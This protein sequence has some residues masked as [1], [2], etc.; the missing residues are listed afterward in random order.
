MI[1]DDGTANNA[2]EGDVVPDEIKLSIV[3]RQ[4]S[5]RDTMAEIVLLIENVSE[6]LTRKFKLRN[7]ALR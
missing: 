1:E 2:R 4:Q 5:I 3:I 6:S 7:N